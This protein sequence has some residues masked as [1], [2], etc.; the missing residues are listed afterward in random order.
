MNRLGPIT[1][2]IMEAA[3]GGDLPTAADRAR[4]RAQLR[5]RLA[6]GA[7]VTVAGAAKT[8]S[9]MTAAKAALSPALATAK[10]LLPWGVAT[11]L[12]PVAVAAAVH[13][14]E[15][16]PVR[17]A[18]P[19]A[20]VATAMVARARPAAPAKVVTSPRPDEVEAPEP[21]ETPDD[22]APP[23]PTD[24]PEQTPA[25]E[26]APPA[27]H[28]RPGSGTAQEVPA[29]SLRQPAR[30]THEASGGLAAVE[31]P[32]AGLAPVEAAKPRAEQDPLVL[33]NRRLREIHEALQRGDAESALSMLDGAK[34]G[35]QALREERSASR[36][37]ALCALGKT[38]EASAAIA[39][40]LRLYPGSLQAHRVRNA[41]GTR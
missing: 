19:A 36:V 6:V 1:R 38:A 18:P 5:R 2:S 29:A 30:P 39:E 34:E 23:E 32:A 41:C 4:V 13:V 37:Y 24:P 33:E 22:I 16:S 26:Q 40:F 12:A 15:P 31:A 17:P 25:T 7:A 9:A 10:G 11:V 35:G 27:A 3:D 28:E 14:A 8:S 20:A 21:A